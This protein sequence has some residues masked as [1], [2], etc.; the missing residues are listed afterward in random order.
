MFH[1]TQNILDH[2]LDLQWCEI[3]EGKKSYQ[4]ISV[5]E[6]IWSNGFKN[7]FNNYFARSSKNLRVLH[8]FHFFRA[9]MKCKSQPLDLKQQ[10]YFEYRTTTCCSNFTVSILD[11]DNYMYIRWYTCWQ[12]SSTPL[13]IVHKE[14][15]YIAFNIFLVWSNYMV[16]PFNCL[17][18]ILSNYFG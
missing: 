17:N 4:K 5:P 16:F 9:E 13:F 8:I 2:Q 18:S 14:G 12:D 10:S 3:E 7:P 15:L 6:S 1:F 11:W